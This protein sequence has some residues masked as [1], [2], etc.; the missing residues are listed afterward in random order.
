MGT[1]G[2]GPEDPGSGSREK[3]TSSGE[4]ISGLRTRQD[5]P[6]SSGGQVP[7]GSHTGAGGPVVTSPGTRTWG[8]G[9]VRG[10]KPPA[11][12]VR[13]PSSGECEV[14]LLSE[15]HF[16]Y[17]LLGP[18]WPAAICLHLAMNTGP[19]VEGVDF[20][21]FADKG[22][23]TKVVTTI[24]T[25]QRVQ[26]CQV[27]NNLVHVFITSSNIY[28]VS[29]TCQACFRL[30]SVNTEMTLVNGTIYVVKDRQLNQQFQSRRR[31]SLMQEV[32]AML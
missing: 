14:V 13:V 17:P 19:E 18:T 1:G 7:G 16:H 22:D 24:A 12:W 15:V 30:G 3:G 28:R 27:L 21:T 2:W 9:V 32:C 23:L 5:L 29:L 6:Y 20:T 31:N 25:C 11:P 4:W 26:A 8:R 10:Q